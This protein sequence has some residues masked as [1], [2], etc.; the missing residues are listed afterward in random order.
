MQFSLVFCNGQSLKVLFFVPLIILG[1]V[2]VRLHASPLSLG[3]IICC[4]LTADES[5]YKVIYNTLLESLCCYCHTVCLY[6]EIYYRLGFLE[7]FSYR[8]Q[9]LTIAY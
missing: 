8:D 6:I 5:G 9:L 2:R 7:T 3:D 4:Y 1:L